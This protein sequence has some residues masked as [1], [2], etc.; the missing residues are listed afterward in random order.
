MQKATGGR[1]AYIHVPNTA[2]GGIQ[3]FSKSYYPQVDKQGIIVDERFNGGGFIPDFF[4]E[5][6]MR[7]DVDLLVE[8]RLRVVPYAGAEH[9]RAEVHSGQ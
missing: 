1:V 5:K 2:I 9:R 6:L 8:S 7:H 4:V 3:E